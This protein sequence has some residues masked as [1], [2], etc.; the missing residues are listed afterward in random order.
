MVSPTP[1]HPNE[2]DNS[3]PQTRSPASADHSS[4]LRAPDSGATDEIS[5]DQREVALWTGRTHWAHF[6]GTLVVWLVLNVAAA[7]VLTLLVRRM[8]WFSGRA[9]LVAF[10]AILVLT[11]IELIG[12]R[13]LWRILQKRY[14]LTTERLFIETG[15]INRTID[16]TELVRIDDV[17]VHKNL[18]DRIVG[19]GSVEIVSTDATHGGV[20]IEGVA[21][22]DQ[23]AESIR[24]N[25]RNLRRKSLYIENL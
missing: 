1:Q 17:R 19:L 15:V 20:V 9:A 2:T 14:R 12:R 7:V 23:V 6:L 8:Q 13:V 11:T 24:T 4:R 22:A 18:L 5:T 3:D 21:G 25:M 16:Q 10:G